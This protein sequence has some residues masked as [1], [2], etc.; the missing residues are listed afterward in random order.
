[1]RAIP[2]WIMKWFPEVLRYTYLLKEKMGVK[3][4]KTR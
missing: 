4:E 3:P 1:M 2:V